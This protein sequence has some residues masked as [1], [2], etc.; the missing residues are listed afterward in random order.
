MCNLNN[1]PTKGFK[2]Y[3]VPVKIKGFGTFP[4]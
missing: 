4:V 1:V 2:F 3:A